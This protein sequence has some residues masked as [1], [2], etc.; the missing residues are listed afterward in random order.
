MKDSQV[1]EVIG[2]TFYIAFI[3]IE[4]VP[5]FFPVGGMKLNC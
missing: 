2:E 4:K 3:A 1:N 5:I